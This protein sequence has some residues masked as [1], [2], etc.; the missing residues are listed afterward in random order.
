MKIT[1]VRYTIL[2]NPE[3]FGRF[4][5]I[6]RV[7]ELRR[8]QYTDKGI[9]H[10]PARQAFI[11]IPSVDGHIAPPDGPGWGAEWDEAR[12]ESLI[13]ATEGAQAL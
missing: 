13:V 7:P 12:F 10:G 4:N 11:D 1:A 9:R 3:G 2:E 8:I 6:V 5:Q